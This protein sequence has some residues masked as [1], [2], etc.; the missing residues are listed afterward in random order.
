MALTLTPAARSAIAARQVAVGW[1][2]DLHLD[3][4]TVYVCDKSIAITYGGETYEPGR[5]LWRV[6]SDIRTSSELVAQ[7]LNLEFDL[8]R[9]LDNQSLI[10]RLLDGDWHQR[11]MKL[12]GLLFAA[13][14]DFA[15]IIGEHII[16]EGRMDTIETSESPG[17]PP[18]AVLSCESGIFRAL[19]RNMTTCSHADQLRRDPTDQ[20]F[21]QTALKPLQEIPFGL[22][23][24]KVPGG[25]GSR[26]GGG[27]GAR[28][29]AGVRLG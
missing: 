22:S 27:G 2:L 6:A 28:S 7:P 23:W 15:T 5:N 4:G 12:T 19:G 29:G 14:E 10:G 13:G 17:A 1:L 25:G 18:V 16:W 11:R 20:F 3:G 26:S 9:Q 8:T 24:S 21:A